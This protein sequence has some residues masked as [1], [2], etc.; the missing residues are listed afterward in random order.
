MQ[1]TILTVG[2][3]KF[4]FLKEGEKLYLDRLSHYAQVNMEFIRPVKYVQSNPM[5]GE[6]AKL[7]ARI[8]EGSLVCTLDRSGKQLSS[9]DFALQIRNWQNRSVS[10]LIF[11]IGGPW[12][13]TANFIQNSDFV[14]SLS[15]M[16]F[17]HDL[18]RIV[19]LEQ[20]Y[21]AFTIL[22]GEKYHK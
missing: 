18:V 14:L 2:D 13:L 1:I 10:K 22:K 21:R 4:S 7:E 11:C 9:D 3:N 5:A 20:L 15:S 19:F 12:G 16:T 6:A 8:S 17:P